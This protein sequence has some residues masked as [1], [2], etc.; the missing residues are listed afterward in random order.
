MEL[1]GCDGNEQ[2]AA[3]GSPTRGERPQCPRAT[4][5]QPLPAS[6]RVS[7]RSGPAPAS[8]LSGALLCPH[9]EPLGAPRGA[10]ASVRV[11]RPDCCACPSSLFCLSG[12]R[13][14]ARARPGSPRALP[15]SQGRVRPRLGPSTGQPE[16]IVCDKVF[17]KKNITLKTCREQCTKRA[18][19]TITKI[20]NPFSSSSAHGERSCPPAQLL[21]LLGARFRGRKD[22]IIHTALISI[23]PWRTQGSPDSLFVEVLSFI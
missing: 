2:A 19:V 16:G 4:R 8:A 20:L 6:H 12:P 10:S 15:P 5:R 18:N 9:A 21:R 22:L 3:R 14:T 17:D 1:R 11:L 7:G 13:P 23:S